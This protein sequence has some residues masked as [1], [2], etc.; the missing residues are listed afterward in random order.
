M[1]GRNLVQGWD[2][3]W[4]PVRQSR[5]QGR[6]WRTA[7]HADRHRDLLRRGLAPRSQ[8]LTYTSPYFRDVEFEIDFAQGE[9]ATLSINTCDRPNRPPGLPCEELSIEQVYRRTG[10]NATVVPGNAIPIDGAGDDE[11]WSDAE[12]HDAMQI[13]WARFPASPQA[14]WAMWVFFGSLHA[15]DPALNLTDPKQLG[16]IVFD[17]IGPNHRQGTA[18][19]NDSFIAEAPGD[20]ANPEAWTRRMTFWTAVHEMGHGFNLAHA[21]Q[22]AVGRGWITLTNEP[23]ARSFMNYPYLVTGGS[24]A[25]FADSP[26]RFGDPKFRASMRHA[27][28]RFTQ[29]GNA[30]W[31]DNHGFQRVNGAK[32]HVR[33]GRSRQSR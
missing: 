20:D 15:P 17:Q 23:E 5:H 9:T 27:P 26:Y 4:L 11:L 8:V 31:F 32:R 25:F 30:D 21:W 22:R 1:A 2:S 7:C 16:G 14:Q 3:R 29:M 10:F 6:R 33:A 28:E 24:P 18:I 12:L 19:F 13:F